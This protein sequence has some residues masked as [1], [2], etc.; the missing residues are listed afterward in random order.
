MGSDSFGSTHSVNHNYC[1]FENVDNRLE[2]SLSVSITQVN[3]W[4]I[5]WSNAP[6]NYMTV[7][8]SEQHNQSCFALNILLFCRQTTLLFILKLDSPAI[9]LH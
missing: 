3:K 7:I 5:K 6:V 2:V 8:S 9:D 4:N 1:G